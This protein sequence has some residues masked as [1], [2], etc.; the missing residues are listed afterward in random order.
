MDIHLH[1][2]SNIHGQDSLAAHVTRVVEGAL[3]R[4]SDKI[5]RVEVHLSDEN[6]AKSG[7]RDKRCMIEAR[8]KG[9]QPAAVTEFAATVEAAIDGAIAKME[10]SLE[11]TIERRSD[12]R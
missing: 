7:Q 9:L 1:T 5:T 10:R 11:T 4:F 6:G 3:D 12:R 8:V 2:D